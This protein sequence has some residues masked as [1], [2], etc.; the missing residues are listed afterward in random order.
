M[1]PYIYIY[2]YLHIHI[3]TYR[4]SDR[5]IIL[6]EEVVKDIYVYIYT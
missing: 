6:L 2:M 5:N 4:E 3:H 1:Y